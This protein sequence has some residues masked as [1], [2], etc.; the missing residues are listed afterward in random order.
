METTDRRR[1]DQILDQE[2]VSDL[3][4]A[5]IEELRRR[6]RLCDD[7]D[8]ELSY[9]RRLLHGR[10]DLAAFEL[11]RRR[12]LESRSILEAL[13]DILTGNEERTITGKV[14]PVSLPHLPAV[15]RRAIDRALNDDF[16][17][18]LPDIDDEELAAI[19]TVLAD[20]EQAVSTQRRAMYEV[21]DQVHGELTRRY[22]EGLADA[23][24]LLHP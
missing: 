13:A 7:V 16:L 10:M 8:I 2:F 3:A 20:T 23:D 24:Q 21:Y 22:S 14:V 12:G 15:G 19:Q 17:T 1:I 5:S 4:D 18:R 9:Y 11:R 6:R